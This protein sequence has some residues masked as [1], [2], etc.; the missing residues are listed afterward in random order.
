MNEELEVMYM[1]NTVVIRHK[2]D[3]VAA[4][5]AKAVADTLKERFTTALK[6]RRAK[7]RGEIGPVPPVG[8][9]L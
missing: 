2:G 1:G 4:G 9:G 3:V 8:G 5:S 7:D 6:L